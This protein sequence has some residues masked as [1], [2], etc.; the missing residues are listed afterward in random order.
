MANI[1]SAQK[2][3]RQ[4]KVKRARNLARRTS[5]KSAVKKVLTSIEKS[6]SFEMI[7]KLLQEAE[8]KVARAT[9]KG[10]IKKNT[11]RRKIGR[12]AKK[13]AALKKEQP[14]S[15]KKK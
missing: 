6:D 4:N 3:A 12:L 10:V 11:A 2:Q 7:Q 8:S 5:V 14:S 13:V 15:P 9:G 1:K